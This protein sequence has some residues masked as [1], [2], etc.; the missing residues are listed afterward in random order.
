VVVEDLGEDTDPFS[1][2]SWPRKHGKRI[3][4][5]RDGPGDPKWIWELNRCQDLPLLVS[6]MLVSGDQR[7]ARSP[8][9]GSNPG[10]SRTPWARHRL[11]Q[12]LRG[13]DACDLAGSRIRRSPRLGAAVPRTS[14]A[15]RSCALAGRPVDRARPFDRQLG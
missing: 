7:Y 2:S 12:R 10:S 13:R 6:A 3:D 9:P 4:Y 14:G 11:E 1:G 8:P 15:D 5:R